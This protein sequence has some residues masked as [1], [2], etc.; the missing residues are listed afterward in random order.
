MYSI[1]SGVSGGAQVVTLALPNRSRQRTAIIAGL[2]CLVLTGCPNANRGAHSNDTTWYVGERAMYHGIPVRVLFSPADDALADRVW[3]Y[4]EHVDDVFND[5]RDDSEIGQINSSDAGVRFAISPDLRDAFIAAIELHRRTGGAFDISTGPFRRL[6]RAA[7]E[8]DKLPEPDEVAAVLSWCGLEKVRLEGDI[9]ALTTP[10]LQFDFGGI[11]KGIAVDRVIAMLRTAGVHS[12]FIQVGGETAAFGVSRRGKPHVV[13]LQDP[14]DLEAL[15]DR[16]VDR[17]DGLSVSTSGNYHQPIVIEGRE[18]YHII[19]PTTG[20]PADARL[21]SVSVIFPRTG[22]NWLADGLTTACTVL[23][24]QRGLDLI[25]ASGGEAV[26]VSL[27]AGER[28][29]TRSS[30][31]HNVG[32]AD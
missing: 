18:Y 4:L 5:Y 13:G 22:L 31:W 26:I 11:V 29:V 20:Y 19:D 32:V 21:L 6:W 3:A 30:G 16:V 10:K 28:I 8:D 14:S 24:R 9:L 1:A 23:G 15:S 2:A 12:G 25:E 7:A 27:E 17:G